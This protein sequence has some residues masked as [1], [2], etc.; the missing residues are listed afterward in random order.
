VILGLD[1]PR[2]FSVVTGEAIDA[3]VVFLMTRHTPSHVRGVDHPLG[4]R[5]LADVAVTGRAIN[6]CAYV[7]LVLEVDHRGR[8][9]HVHLPPQQRLPGL[10]VLHE[11][12]DL[13][14]VRNGAAPVTD[15]A[16]RNR[17]QSRFGLTVDALV[18]PR[19]VDVVLGMRTMIERDRLLRRRWRF[20]ATS[21]KRGR[22]REPK[23]AEARTRSGA[24]DFQCSTGLR[25][26]RTGQ[27]RWPGGQG[28]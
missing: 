4:N 24:V 18:A 23:T 5:H 21:Q 14:V 17:R 9:H 8:R 3:R 7:R 11:L 12:E 16:R 22:H 19:A 28:D 10:E 6:F 25:N 15:G 2:W 26:A 13:G 27:T 20:G 1:C